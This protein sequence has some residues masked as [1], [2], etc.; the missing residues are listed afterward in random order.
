V[1]ACTTKI[2]VAWGD[3][4]GSSLAGRNQTIGKR[5]YI[6]ADGSL[7]TPGTTTL[8]ATFTND[9]FEHVWTIPSLSALGRSNPACSGPPCAIPSPAEPGRGIH[10]LAL[11]TGSRTLPGP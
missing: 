11:M 3:G 6:R 5:Y 7:V 8:T 9:P 4:Y 2:N 10:W 1:P